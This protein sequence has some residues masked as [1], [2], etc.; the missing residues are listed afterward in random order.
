MTLNSTVLDTTK[1]IMQ[2]VALDI[3]QN[4]QGVVEVYVDVNEVFNVINKACTSSALHC[5]ILLDIVCVDWLTNKEKRFDL[6]YVLRSLTNNLVLHVRTSL[7]ED[8]DVESVTG[9]YKGA[10]WLE[11]EV[12][13]M[14]GIVFNNHPNL[15]RILSDY[16]FQGHP[17]R[18]DFPLSGHFE[19]RYD[20]VREKIVYEDVKLEQDFRRFD[21]LSP[22]LGTP[23]EQ[24]NS[25]AESEKEEEGK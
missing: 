8:E 12:W 3:K 4:K 16:G 1:V 17:L 24:A 7:D 2:G 25:D 19:V 22:W 14:Y 15:R 18:K 9:L 23:E 5:E 21:T 13:D 20:E 11:R 10:N 6:I